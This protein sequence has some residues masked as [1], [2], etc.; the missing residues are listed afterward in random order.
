MA[1]RHHGPDSQQAID[2]ARNL[3]AANLERYV[4]EIVAKAPPLTTEQLDRITAIL[5]GGA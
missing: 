5:R 2:A 4:D 1:V 3:A